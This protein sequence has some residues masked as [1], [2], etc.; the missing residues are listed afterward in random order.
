[1]ADANPET[2]ISVKCTIADCPGDYEARFITHTV[3]RRGQIIVFDHVPA[4]VCD[5]CGDVLLRPETIRRIE[6]L[7]ASNREPEATVPLFEYA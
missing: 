5:V 2:G 3:R 6:Y 7:V 1:M 4:E